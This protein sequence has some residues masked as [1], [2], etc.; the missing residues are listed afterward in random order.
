MAEAYAENGFPTGIVADDVEQ[1]SG[2]GGDA[3][4]GGEDYLVELLELLHLELVVAIY[5]DVGS[6]L[7]HEVTQVV[8]KRVVVVNYYYLHLYFISSAMS[9]ARRRAPSLL[10][11]SWSSY[12]SSLLAT[13]PP[14]AWNHSSPPR[15][16][17]V[18]M[19]MA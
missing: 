9:I 16:T 6:K 19:V 18:R 5:G 17:K 12:S 2:F 15:L 10:F 14:P 7:A 8:G 13:M 3:G 1:E 4:A 11:T